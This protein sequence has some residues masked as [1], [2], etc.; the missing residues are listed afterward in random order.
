MTEILSIIVCSIEVLA[1][2][3]IFVIIVVSKFVL[4]LPFFPSFDISIIPLGSFYNTTEC[5]FKMIY[6]HESLLIYRKKHT[7]Y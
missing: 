1:Q 7:V 5:M 6:S 2:T 4:P 3:F